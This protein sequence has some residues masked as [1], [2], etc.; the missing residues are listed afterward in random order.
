MLT[1]AE[2]NAVH[3]LEQFGERLLFIHKADDP[4]LR[5][6][7]VL[8]DEDIGHGIPGYDRT[9]DAYISWAESMPRDFE[10]DPAGGFSV[11]TGAAYMATKALQIGIALGEVGHAQEGKLEAYYALLQKPEQLKLMSKVVG[12]GLIENQRRR[13]R[14]PFK[15]CPPWWLDGTLERVAATIADKQCTV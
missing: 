3:R 4:V 1:T 15:Q 8:T 7:I 14:F 9:L 5:K 11:C 2:T 12:Y 10:D 13:L 6:H